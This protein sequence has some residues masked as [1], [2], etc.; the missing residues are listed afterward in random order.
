MRCTL[1]AQTLQ[2]LQLLGRFRGVSHYYFQR[3]P[4]LSLSLRCQGGGGMYDDRQ[5][6]NIHMVSR[7]PNGR[8]PSPAQPVANLIPAVFKCIV[9]TDGM[10]SAASVLPHLLLGVEEIR[11]VEAR[12]MIHGG[13]SAILI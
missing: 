8:V 5:I 3:N 1:L 2:D 10:E 12:Q 4:F 7:E 13:G 9:Q 6:L 11:W